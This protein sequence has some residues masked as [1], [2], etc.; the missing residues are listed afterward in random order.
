[1][2]I[3]E[4]EDIVKGLPDQVLFQE[5]QYP[6]GQIPQYLAVSEVQRRQEMRQRFQSQQQG[7]QPTIKDQILQGGIAAAGAPPQISQPPM[8]APAENMQTAM[9]D[10][11]ITRMFSGGYTPGGTVKMQA[12][13]ST[14]VYKFENLSPEARQT[15]VRQ[16]AALGMNPSLVMTPEGFNSQPFEKR[17]KL[18]A[19][20]SSLVPTPAQEQPKAPAPDTSAF[21]QSLGSGIAG[22]V[23]P[24]NQTIT[25]MIPLSGAVGAPAVAST[26]RGASGS[27]DK[28]TNPP[29]VP[30][31][32][33]SAA[34]SVEAGIPAA[35]AALASATSTA[36][37]PSIGALTDP[38]NQAYASMFSRIP[39]AYQAVKNLMPQVNEITA[40]ELEQ[41]KPTQEDYLNP[42]IARQREELLTQFRAQ[43][44]LRK[45]EDMAAAERA[46]KESEAPI[47]QSLEDARRAAIASSLMRLGA[48]IASGN[49]AEGLASASESVEQ[50]MGRAREQATAERRA[51]RQEF[52]AAERE[53]T[54][55]ERSVADTAFQMQASNITAN[56]NAQRDLVRDQKSFAQWAYGQ[57]RDAGREARQAQ[58]DSVKLSIGLAQAIDQTVRDALRN[59]A[60]SENQ[61]TETFGSVFKEVLNEI[62]DSD[63]GKDEN[64]DPIIPTPK[65]LLEEAGK[66]TESVLARRGILSPS[67][68][69]DV[70]S[71]Q[72]LSLLNSG[73][74]Y[75]GPDG[76][77]RI[78]P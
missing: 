54:R 32:A 24:T 9:Y 52:R 6:S 35:G 39:E 61:Y 14:D 70:T 75:R 27:L 16:Y 34:P 76:V 8:A 71:Q 67:S 10:G 29:G 17:Q 37:T 28:P 51:S 31:Q 36:S 19:Q 2:N 42:Q 58:G 63:W 74:Y 33:P 18:F 43:G 1:M 68:V 45:K 20:L 30:V 41:F 7:Q 44:G 22:V 25:G 3:I 49:A 48:G 72:Q 77:T 53:A 21:K 26:G 4:A 66:Q 64:G 69:I 47:Q 55:A 73:Q 57:M 65:Q 23:P 59:R 5:A 40:A 62:K 78:K 15:I 38:T 13:R 56:E 11:G 12:G 60:I 46:M 50:I